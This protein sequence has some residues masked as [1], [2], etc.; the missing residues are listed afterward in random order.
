MLEKVRTHL[1]QDENGV[2]SEFNSDKRDSDAQWYV[3]ASR[4]W[5][6]MASVL[7]LNAIKGMDAPPGR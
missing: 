2:S 1:L 5:A 4:T 6:W 7:D 3:A